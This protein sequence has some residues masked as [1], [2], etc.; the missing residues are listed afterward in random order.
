MTTHNFPVSHS[1]DE[2]HSTL[3][4]SGVWKPP[5][6]I[7]G[8]GSMPVP[9]KHLTSR[10][11]T[12]ASGRPASSHGA[13]LRS[14][15][16]RNEAGLYD[17]G[18]LLQHA[19]LNSYAV[20]ERALDHEVKRH[21]LT[22]PG[23]T[24]T[25]GERPVSA[26]V[27]SKA[28]MSLSG[29][30]DTQHTLFHKPPTPR[31]ANA[32]SSTYPS[33]RV[34]HTFH[35]PH[36]SAPP[37]ARASHFASSDRGSMRDSWPEA[38]HHHFAQSFDLGDGAGSDRHSGPLASFTP[39]GFATTSHLSHPLHQQQP[40]T[41]ASSSSQQLHRSRRTH[42]ARGEMRWG[43][44]S[45]TIGVGRPRSAPRGPPPNPSSLY[46]QAQAA[47]HA[48]GEG[49]PHSRPP[50]ASP[51]SAGRL[52]SAGQHRS[53]S[54]PRSSTRPFSGKPSA[55][56]GRPSVWA[57]PPLQVPATPTR[58][59][60]A[61]ARSPGHAAEAWGFETGSVLGSAN[62]SGSLNGGRPSTA[63]TMPMSFGGFHTRPHT[64]M[65]G[66]SHLEA[67]QAIV[68]PGKFPVCSRPISGFSAASSATRQN[69]AAAAMM[70]LNPNNT[71]VA[72]QPVYNLEA[73]SHEGIC[74]SQ[75]VVDYYTQHGHSAAK[76]LFYLNKAVPPSPYDIIS[77]FDGVVVPASKVEREHWTMSV[78]GVVQITQ[79]E[80]K[81]AEFTE[82]GEWIRLSS[83]YSLLRKMRFFK[84]YY[85][86]KSFTHWRKLVRR[87]H[88]RR[89]RTE[90]G[91][92]LFHSVPTFQPCLKHVRGLLGEVENT[93]VLAISNRPDKLYLIEDFVAEQDDHR[94]KVVA[95]NLSSK[96]AQVIESIIELCGE[97]ET[98]RLRMETMT[99]IQVLVDNDFKV[100]IPSMVAGQKNK[101]ISAMKE[102]R[103]A[104][105]HQY[106]RICHECS[107]LR[108]FVR[109]ID[110]MVGVTIVNVGVS[111]AQDLLAYFKDPNK[112]RGCF[113][114]T[115]SYLDRPKAYKFEPPHALVAEL[116]AHVIDCA[117][118]MVQ[119]LPRPLTSKHL[120]TKFMD[121]Y[122]QIMNVQSTAVGTVEFQTTRAECMYHVDSSYKQAEEYVVA[123]FEANRQ[124]E[125]ARVTWSLADYESKPHNLSSI[126]QDLL[127]KKIW[128]R[129]IDQM[130]MSTNIGILFVDSKSMRSLLQ[131]H[132]TTSIED[133]K[134]VLSALARQNCLVA[135]E[136]SRAWNKDLE[137]R[138][139]DLHG[140]A[141]LKQRHQ[142]ME[143][144]KG[145][146]FKVVQAVDDMWDTFRD[147]GGKMEKDDFLDMSTLHTS[148]NDTKVRLEEVYDWVASRHTEMVEAMSSSSTGLVEGVH[149]LL[150]DDL[151]AGPLNDPESDMVSF[152]LVASAVQRQKLRGWDTESDMVSLGLVP[153][154]IQSQTW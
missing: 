87:L 28:P 57:P 102:E 55:A 38:Q 133:I 62:G 23:K 78:M 70:A 86:C 5:G 151:A 40:G 20:E 51:A 77:P 91:R 73:E 19:A 2:R 132:V 153:S 8:A 1:E 121:P 63:N 117:V 33:P 35:S 131:S 45:S 90:I 88:Y 68:V 47:A 128:G 76:K 137:A 123:T 110:Y 138:P 101:S 94:D 46:A 154:M 74:T 124:V 16:G 98:E 105:L 107:R 3:G 13:S 41:L 126:R 152:G 84:Q 4:R 89:V 115:V 127:L 30:W 79:G 11:G 134:K 114:T 120:V 12:A 83:I 43:P 10:P 118:H 149:T 6:V 146:L 85:I 54:V 80:E 81:E 108:H 50:S 143:A 26:A 25:Q 142:G 53:G 36:M 139:G 56:S 112:S 92:M 48:G 39:P 96:I 140:F 95:P 97:V 136:Q 52:R 119:E 150:T 99:D 148:I 24:G 31:S 72:E 58:P 69:P 104:L 103:R 125:N 37:K 7:G 34:E 32:M 130:K 17:G 42:S 9:A 59:T 29:G 66:T 14:M 44:P 60:T 111:A 27:Y 116:T 82:L 93:H 67:S 18:S 106:Q 15:T 100:G 64:P 109:L 113:N 75:D 122:E 61:T 49:H 145:E 129:Q 71:S 144:S 65:S 141:R 135:L 147:Y 22:M 21:L